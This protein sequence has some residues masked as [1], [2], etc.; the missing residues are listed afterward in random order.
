ML[1]SVVWTKPSLLHK[2]KEGQLWYQMEQRGF[3]GHSELILRNKIIAFGFFF[4]ANPFNWNFPRHKY[5][6]R[7]H[8]YTTKF[9]CY[10]ST[11]NLTNSKVCTKLGGGGGGQN[12]YMRKQI[13]GFSIV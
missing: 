6:W 8:L 1:T 5:V 2:P 12:D 9:S 13:I 7:N 3:V 10:T 11:R 4:H